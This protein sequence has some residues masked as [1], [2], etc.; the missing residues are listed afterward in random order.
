MAD[1]KLTDLTELATSAASDDWLYV[2]DKSDTT[3]SA[4]GSSKKI[5]VSNL[6][7]STEGTAILS[8][9]ETGGTK[10]LREDGDGT[11][12]WQTVSGGSPTVVRNTV[13]TSTSITSAHGQGSVPDLVWLEMNGT[14]GRK[15]II[16]RYT[17]EDE[18]NHAV[19]VS[20]D[21]TNLYCNANNTG[22]FNEYAGSNLP[23][24]ISSLALVGVWF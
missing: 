19:A 23:T 15:Y 21:A 24:T 11:C 7:P 12:S 6:V 5:S 20:A 9:G 4:A 13:S 1:Q 3:D 10:F 8:T 2:V 17:E 14:D 16:T 18:N 22:D